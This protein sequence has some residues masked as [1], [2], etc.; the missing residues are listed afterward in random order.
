M[1]IIDIKDSPN[2]NATVK[3]GIDSVSTGKVFLGLAMENIAGRVQM[4]TE[5][6]INEQKAKGWDNYGGMLYPC[7]EVHGAMNKVSKEGLWRC[8]ACGVGCFEVGV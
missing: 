5:E 3:N 7:C 6:E 1:I 4:I 2:F 8:L